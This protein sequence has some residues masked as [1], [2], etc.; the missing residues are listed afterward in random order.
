MC[1]VLPATTPLQGLLALFLCTHREEGDAAAGTSSCLAICVYAPFFPLSYHFS[2][3][4]IYKRNWERWSCIR[5]PL[6]VSV[7]FH[8]CV[9]TLFRIAATATTAGGAAAAR[10]YA[11]CVDRNTRLAASVCAVRGR[12]IIVILSTQHSVAPRT[13]RAE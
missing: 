5:V 9:F 13:F 1:L 6:S 11:G 3:Y 10:A 8:T 12:E 2:F 7:L 4:N